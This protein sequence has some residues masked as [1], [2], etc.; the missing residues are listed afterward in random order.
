VTGEHSLFESRLGDDGPVWTHLDADHPE[1][2]DWLGDTAQSIDNFTVDALLA[3]ETRPRTVDLA[4]EVLVILRGVN[5]N[6]DAEPED[7]ISIR[8]LAGPNRI[9]TA[10]KRQLKAVLDLKSSVSAGIGPKNAGDFIYMLIAGLSKRME[11]VLAALDDSTDGIEER[12]LETADSRLREE[13]VEIRKRAIIL[14]RYIAPQ[15]D[16]IGQL[17]TLDLDWLGTG[18]KRHLLENLDRVTRYVEDL[19]AIRERAQIVKDEIANILADR[20]NRNTYI[21]TLVAGIF[22]PLGFLTGLLG[23]NVG[24]IPGADNPAA[25]WMF[26]LF[27]ALI[28]AG[29]I[30]LFRRLRWF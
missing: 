12:L 3:E 2:R 24:G 16:A 30:L 13:I 22:L 10:Q 19:D 5:L 21:L 20:L 11:P 1:T 14:R 6:E 27:L 18:H 25:F 8:V 17:R 26:C 7:M 23:I 9:I 29:L 28:V 15:R 4:G